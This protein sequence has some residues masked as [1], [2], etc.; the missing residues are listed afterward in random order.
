M[1]R[2][3][4]LMEKITGKNN[5]DM[6]YSARPETAVSKTPIFSEKMIKPVTD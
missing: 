6:R 2:T 5:I 1:R 3:R 4:L